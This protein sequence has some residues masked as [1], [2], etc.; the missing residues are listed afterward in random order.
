MR[1][2]SVGSDVGVG[3][4]RVGVGGGLA[5]LRLLATLLRAILKASGKPTPLVSTVAAPAIAPSPDAELIA[6]CERYGQ[7]DREYRALGAQGF[8]LDFSD[9]EYRRIERIL[10]S[11]IPGIQAMREQITETP[12]ITIDGVR[13]KATAARYWLTVDG[14]DG[15]PALMRDEDG[16]SWS[17]VQDLLRIV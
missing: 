6:L 17:L 14:D 13:A 11:R 7:A 3:G 10:R 15:K 16:P 9:P 1:E 8:Y 5:T 12:A 2:D 4:R